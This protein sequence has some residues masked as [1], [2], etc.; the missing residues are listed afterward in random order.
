ML[1]RSGTIDWR[2]SGQSVHNLVRALT[3]PYAGAHFIY[4]GQEFKVWKTELLR[5]AADRINVEPGKV[6]AVKGHSITIKC[7]EGLVR[8]VVH[9]CHLFSYT[10]VRSKQTGRPSAIGL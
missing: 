2:M 9:D 5:D 10:G 8:L 7:G 6:V 3:K 1:F 4:Q